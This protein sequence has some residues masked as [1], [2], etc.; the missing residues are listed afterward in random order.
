MKRPVTSEDFLFCRAGT[1]TVWSSLAIV[2]FK[3]VSPFRMV[4]TVA[5]H[6]EHTPR[7]LSL[8]IL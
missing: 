1:N 6:P 3:H 2:I 4:V 5:G 8:F 7:P